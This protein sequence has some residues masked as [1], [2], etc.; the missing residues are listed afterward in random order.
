MSQPTM[1]AR[2][3][4]RGHCPLIVPLGY[5]TSRMLLG[6]S[7]VAV[8]SG[9]DSDSAASPKGSPRSG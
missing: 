4:R 9:A 7:T 2:S 5:R 8:H 6:I 3:K 1:T